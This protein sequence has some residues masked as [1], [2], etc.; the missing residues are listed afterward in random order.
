MNSD[1]N[2]SLM[3]KNFI[4]F[5]RILGVYVTN[6]KD[7]PTLLANLSD[8][9]V[10]QTEEEAWKFAKYDWGAVDFDVLLYEEEMIRLI[11]ES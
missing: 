6:T 4:I 11:M 3:C 2:P 1:S 9:V 8:A 7:A 5:L 10:F